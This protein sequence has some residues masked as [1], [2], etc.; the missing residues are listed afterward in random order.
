MIQSDGAVFFWISCLLL[1]IPLDWL[2]AALLAALF[3]E[4][5]HIAVLLLLGGNIRRIQ[6]SLTGCVIESS[7]PGD[8]QSLCSILAGP[9]GSLLLVLL[10]RTVPK[11]A[12]CG[13][14][15]GLYNLLPLY[16]LDGGRMLQLLLIRF[17]PEKADAVLLV[18][19]RI[20]CTVILI[21]VIL[22][23]VGLFPVIL[24]LLWVLRFF[25]RKIP[26]KPPG[27]KV[28]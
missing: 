6:I 9:A 13:L 22:A 25:P 27:I 21:A 4:A 18:T 7:A 3:H 20:L 12:V 14:L 8:L 23:P 1:L 10:Y 11:M 16:P 17:L 28:Q 26:C 15:H 19:G 5:C 24:V 2:L